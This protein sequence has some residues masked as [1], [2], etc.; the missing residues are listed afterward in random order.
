MKKISLAL[1]TL[2][3]A[4]A[5][6]YAANTITFQGEVSEQTCEVT[7]NGTASSPIVLLP[8]V[9]TTDLAASGDTAG[10]TPFEVGV[11]GCTA[12]TT[13]TTI[14]TVFVG[15]NVA[16]T[17][18]LTNTGTATNVEV[19]VLDTASAVIDFSST[20]EGDA[21]ITLAAGDTAA[22]ATYNV[23]YYATGASTAGTVSASLQYAVSYL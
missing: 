20:Y 14:T 22:S 1:L 6:A 5:P 15:N 10:Q 3:I 21:D 23:Q 8:T 17:G 16:D 11:T 4:A 9:S 18:N 19:Q 7:V 2:A 13:A 12:A